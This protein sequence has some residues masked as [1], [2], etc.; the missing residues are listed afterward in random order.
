[1]SFK[2][3]LSPVLAV[4][5]AALIAMSIG[6]D[7]C[8]SKGESTA[9]DAGGGSNESGEYVAVLRK[10]R[11][12]VAADETYDAY[13]Y[14]EYMPSTQRA[15][16]DAFCF[17]VDR[18]LKNPQTAE[19]GDPAN[20]AREITRKAESDLKSERNIVAPGPARRAIGRLRV[21]LGLET[22]NRD[23][24]GRYARACYH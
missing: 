6:I 18:G 14:A 24:A 23:L 15:A 5:A 21:I 20:L 10:F 17:I 13:G 22:L 2:R 8:G 7:G 11:D 1:M 16:I 3:T 12:A 4:G 9:A 19:L